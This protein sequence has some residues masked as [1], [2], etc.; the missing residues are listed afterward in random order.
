MPIRKSST[1]A[2]RRVG[3]QS[4]LK[5]FTDRDRERELLRNFFERLAHPRSRAKKPILSIWGV[6]GIGKT[7][8]LKKA[9]EELGGDLAGL[10]LIFL[11]LDH[12]RWTP[13]TPVAEF[14]WQMRSQLWAAK[15]RGT[16]G[17]HGIETSLFDYLYF[18]LW[19]AQ[20]PGE[21]FD[22]SDSVLKDLLNTSTQGSNIIAEAS[23]NL[24]TASSAAAGLV[25]LLDKGLA[26]LRNRARKGF[27][28]KRGLNPEAMTV[29]EMETELGPMLTADLERWLEDGVDVD[30]GSKR[31]L[32]QRYAKATDRR[33]YV[34]P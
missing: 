26:P 8:L 32:A 7:S 16:P 5:L 17:G 4:A 10:R 31:S 2:G 25:F 27:L 22:L 24:G 11:D 1:A 14:F 30:A 28:R 34:N 33:N 29:K 12:D 20:H 21:R 6:G 13:S 18:A 15:P 23:A 19:R 9:V 3:R